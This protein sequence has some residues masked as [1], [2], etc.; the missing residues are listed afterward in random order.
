MA[1]DASSCTVSSSS[2][3]RAPLGFYAVV[4]ALTVAAVYL[5][6]KKAIERSTRYT[7][8][9]TIYHWLAPDDV[10]HGEGS[11]V[12]A[13]V[14]PAGVERTIRS[15]QN[16]QRALRQLGWKADT[17][18]KGLSVA[19]L[20]ELTERVRRDLRVGACKATASDP[21]KISVTYTAADGRDA[22][23]LVNNLAEEYAGE[24]RTKAEAAAERAYGEARS[25]MDRARGQL[26]AAKEQFDALESVPAP[27]P[28]DTASGLGERRSQPAGETAEPEA[29]T[30]VP[31]KP[32]KTKN[33]EWV[34]VNNQFARL[35]RLRGELL[36]D[37]T[38][39]HPEVQNLD[40]KMGRL[41]QRLASIDKWLLNEP[42]DPVR[43]LPQLEEPPAGEPPPRPVGPSPDELA[44]K[45]A[46]RNRTFQARK[47]A[48]E[49][50]LLAYEQAA[51]RQRGAWQRQLR[52]P[53]IDLQLAQQ[54]EVVQ[55]AGRLGRLLLMALAA[56][57][58][59]SAGAGML[60]TGAGGNPPFA[61]A[62]GAKAALPVPVVGTISAVDPP[63]GDALKAR[64]R[65]IDG[66]VMVACGLALIVFCIVTLTAVLGTGG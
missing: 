60:S 47:K 4:F 46:E 61:T 11:A 2:T 5:A 7:A 22:I 45:L 59:M 58:V 44:T 31:A 23:Q 25:A 18:Q 9:A 36:V 38:P 28:R 15:S 1:N 30:V 54:H 3:R 49:Q 26:T 13:Q 40:V 21:L 53:R 50:A 8:T 17:G 19:P 12:L 34:A 65:R 52:Q 32:E 43:T 6:G 29:T 66:R 27:V 24:H 51:A 62:A 64:S 35:E 55:S 39:L 56:G 37:R 57:L 10:Q 16:I 14:D 63:E 48:L 42:S 41:E 20:H 33:P